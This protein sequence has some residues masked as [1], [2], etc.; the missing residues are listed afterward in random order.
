M[1]QTGR[2]VGGNDDASLSGVSCLV[3]GAAHSCSIN[4]EYRWRRELSNGSNMRSSRQWKCVEEA[5]GDEKNM[6]VFSRQ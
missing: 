4:F 2:F 3:G 6:G 5:E 1:R